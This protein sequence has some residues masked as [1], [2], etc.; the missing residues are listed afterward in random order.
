[1]ALNRGFSFAFRS[2]RAHLSRER[3]APLAHIDQGEHGVGA[4]GILGQPTITHLGKAP[5]TLEREE[6]MLDDRAHRGLAP[7]RVLFTTAAGMIA[8]LTKAL[9]EGRLEDKL[10]PGLVR[11]QEPAQVS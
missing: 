7:V 2:R 1:L 3:P 4:V 8:T 10:K 5:Q 11:P 9:N 6:R